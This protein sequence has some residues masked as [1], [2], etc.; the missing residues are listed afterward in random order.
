MKRHIP[1]V[2]TVISVVSLAVAFLA[3]SGLGGATVHAVKSSFSAKKSA[4]PK[5][6]TKAGP[7]GPRGPRGLRGRIGPQGPKGDT[8]SQ[9]PQGSAGPQGAVGP[10]GAK[11]DKGDLGPTGMAIIAR[12]RDTG[13]L[14]TNGA[15]SSSPR[16]WPLTGNNWTQGANQVNAIFG[17]VTVAV[18][19]GC[20]VSDFGSLDVY[21]DGEVIGT[22]GVL[23]YALSGTFII[24]F[25]GGGSTG[26][27]Y[28][29]GAAAPHQITAKIYDSCTADMTFSNLKIDVASLN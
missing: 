2:P 10:Q 4:A 19:A 7:R 11:G 15:T 5:L 29:P 6:S 23:G 24:N 1:T 16:N 18:P 3:L 9:G 22:S 28:E 20:G 17:Q 13:T 25:G 27:R 8:G 12:I 21:L 26:Y 14:S